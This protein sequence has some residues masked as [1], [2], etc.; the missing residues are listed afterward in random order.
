MRDVR[1][2]RDSKRIMLS[3]LE[4]A[5]ESIR[6]NLLMLTKKLTREMQG[7]NRFDTFIQVCHYIFQFVSGRIMTNY[8]A[9]NSNSIRC[10]LIRPYRA[11]LRYNNPELDDK[12]VLK[13]EG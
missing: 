4:V 13:T 11:G 12:G 7:K 10:V 9:V 1:S 2:S 6:K 5:R 3:L 8:D